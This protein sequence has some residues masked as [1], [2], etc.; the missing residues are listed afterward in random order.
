MLPKKSSKG[1]EQIGYVTCL[2]NLTTTAVL[3]SVGCSLDSVFLRHRTDKSA[4]LVELRPG[5]SVVWVHRN[6][7]R[8]VGT[9]FGKFLVEPMALKLSQDMWSSGYRVP[10]TKIK[11]LRF[12]PMNK[13]QRVDATTATLYE[14]RDW[15]LLKPKFFDP[16]RGGIGYSALPAGA[17][18]AGLGVYWLLN[19]PPDGGPC[20]RNQF[21]IFVP[22]V[23]T[24][25]TMGLASAVERLIASGPAPVK[26][27]VQSSVAP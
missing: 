14:T 4:G 7:Q 22:V 5:Q 24:S 20:N 11:S 26:P 17:I 2:R 9:Y 1:I 16:E 15:D 8:F 18:G 6:G 13:W 10:S 21:C 3:L 19:L 25:I 12:D 27:A 23:A